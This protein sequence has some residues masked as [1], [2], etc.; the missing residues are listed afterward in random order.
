[1]AQVCLKSLTPASVICPHTN[2]HY[3]AVDTMKAS[4]VLLLLALAPQAMAVRSKILGEVDNIRAAEPD[5]EPQAAEEEPTDEA[6]VNTT[7]ADAWDQV[8]LFAGEKKDDFLKTIQDPK[9]REMVSEK[10]TNAVAPLKEMAGNAIEAIKD[11]TVREKLNTVAAD[12]DTAAKAI[13][14][15]VSDPDQRKV[16]QEAAQAKYQEAIKQARET[17]K[18][19]WEHIEDKDEQTKAK[20]ATEAAISSLK[21]AGTTAIAAAQKAADDALIKHA[22]LF[23]ALKKAGDKAKQDARGQVTK[24]LGSEGD[25]L[26]GASCWWGA[27]S[28]KARDALCAGDMECVREG[29]DGRKGYG[30]CGD[31]H[32][33]SCS[34]TMADSDCK[35]AKA[36]AAAASEAADP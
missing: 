25:R 21:D 16:C 35:N 12:L 33:C 20:E 3:L 18:N 14:A 34:L 8:K 28:V 10:V 17:A 19:T 24:L 1:L 30:D 29:H 4:L 23:A 15:C 36:A 2:K 11:G 7:Y 31:T 13:A 27:G 22:D 32:C 6:P 9:F 5:P 26:H